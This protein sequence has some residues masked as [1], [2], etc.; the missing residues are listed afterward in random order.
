M[1]SDSTELRG[2]EADLDSTGDLWSDDGER[3][4]RRPL[5]GERASIGAMA[6]EK[7]GKTPA[8][9]AALMAPGGKEVVELRRCG[10]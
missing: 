1:G 9:A 2:V 10:M 5:L 3:C 8:A 7:R 4:S 6:T